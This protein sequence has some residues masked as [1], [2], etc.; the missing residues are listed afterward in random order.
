MDALGSAARAGT[1]AQATVRSKCLVWQNTKAG[2]RRG[3]KGLSPWKEK[4]SDRLIL[5][6]AKLNRLPRSVLNHNKR[7]IEPMNGKRISTAGMINKRTDNRALVR[8]EF[9][10][11]ARLLI[12]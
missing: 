9:F 8:F 10:S 12:C 11:Q 1:H 5:H 3:C 7:A 2:D 4:S 6:E